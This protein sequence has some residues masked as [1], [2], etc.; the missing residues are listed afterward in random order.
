MNPYLIPPPAL[1][2]FSGGRTS[3]YMLHEIVRAYDGR[4]PDDVVVAFANTGKEREETLRFVHECATRWGVRVRWLEWRDTEAGFDEVG[5][6]S[7]SRQGE[8]FAALIAKKGGRLPNWSERWCT[9]YLKVQTMF[10]FVRSELGLEPGQYAEV[11][12][13][14][15]DEEMRMWRGRER[16]DRDGRVVAYPLGT[17]K[18]T[19][20]DVMSF[21]ARSDFDLDLSPGAGNCDLCF[22]KSQRTRA[23][24]MRQWPGSAAWWIEAEQ[25]TAGFFDRRTRYADLAAQVRAQGHLF[26]G[27]TDDGD[28]FDAEC[29]LHC[30]AD[31]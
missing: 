15:A 3:G 20:R 2:S 29:G 25:R 13:L 7:A 26:D 10:A 27:F 5:F 23:A 11:I 8:P 14:R 22:L 4:L 9:Q 24:L 30:G 31:A 6:N 16:A 18:I 12:G 28:E 1:I 17:A 21:W 19:K